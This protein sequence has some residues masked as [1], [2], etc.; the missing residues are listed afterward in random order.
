MTSSNSNPFQQS[1]SDSF[2]SIEMLKSFVENPIQ[3]PN[4]MFKFE[5]MNFVPSLE[6]DF[7]VKYLQDVYNPPDHDLQ[8]SRHK[9]TELQTMRQKER[10]IQNVGIKEPMKK[11]D[12]MWE[13]DRNVQ[14]NR[15]TDKNLPGNPYRVIPRNLTETMGKFGAPKP[16]HLVYP[17]QNLAY[18]TPPIV[19]MNNKMVHP[20]RRMDMNLYPDVLKKKVRSNLTPKTATKNVKYIEVI[21]DD[22]EVPPPV[23]KNRKKDKKITQT[24]SITRTGLKNIKTKKMSIEIIDSPEIIPKVNYFFSFGSMRIMILA[25]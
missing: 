14:M 2:C 3:L 13:D 12:M 25:I 15:L 22:S 23:T 5:K 16:V 1:T 6:Y 7:M 11:V 21:D 8:L 10:H 19:A 4:G 24:K 9:Q 17:Y 20:K 18:P